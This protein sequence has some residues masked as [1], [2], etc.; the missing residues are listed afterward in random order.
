MPLIHKLDEFYRNI[1]LLGKQIPKRDHFGI[2]LKIENVLLDVLE[3]II[4]A[5]LETKINK[6][7][8]LNSARI[9]IEILKRLIRLIQ[10]FKIIEANKYLTLEKDLQ[11]ISKMINGWIKYL[12]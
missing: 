1:Y 7:S 6:I 10:E 2:F 12:K 9:K 11:E 3:L 8:P 4:T 5:S